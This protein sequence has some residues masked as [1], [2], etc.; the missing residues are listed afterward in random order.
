MNPKT[1]ARFEVFVDIIYK[2][3]KIKIPTT[4]CKDIK[5]E[6]LKDQLLKHYSSIGTYINYIGYITN[7]ILRNYLT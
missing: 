3:A 6:Q 2:R 4:T 1:R 5:K 7:L